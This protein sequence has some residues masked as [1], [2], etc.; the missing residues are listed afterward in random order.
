MVL[1]KMKNKWFFEAV[2]LHKEDPYK[3]NYAE[4][5]RMFDKPYDC[6]RSRF[7]RAKEKEQKQELRIEDAFFKGLKEGKNIYSLY[8]EFGKELTDKTLSDLRDQ[9]VQIK[10]TPTGLLKVVDFVSVDRIEHTE[11]WKAN[12][13]IYFGLVSDTHLCSKWQQLTNLNKIYDIFLQKKEELGLD[14]LI[15]YH[16][17]DLVEGSGMRKGHE[18]EIIAHGFDAQ[19]DYV[20]K[21]YPLREGITTKFI[22]GNHD[23]VFIRSSGSNIG[24]AI[25]KER[26]DMIYLGSNNARI[27]LTPNCT[28]EINHPWDGS[29]FDNQ[30]EILTDRGWVLFKDLTMNDQCA[31]MRKND[32]TFEWQKPDDIY[33]NDY[34]GEMIHFKSRTV[35]MLVTPNHGM[36]VKEYNKNKVGNKLNFPQKAHYSKD[37]NWRM[38]TA[39]TLLDS[40][41][42]QKWQLTNVCSNWEGKIKSEYIEIPYVESKNVGMMKRMKHIGKIH[43]EDLCKL[44]AW[45]VTEG[46]ADNKKVC[47]CQSKRV[48]PENH[49]DITDLLDKLELKYRISGLDDKDIIISSVELSS[50]LQENCG[51]GSKNV[52]LPS[53]LKELPST[54]LKIIFNT[55]IAG[56]GWLTTTGYGYKSIS[57]RLR[58][59]FSEIAIKLGYSVNI[60]QETV[61]VSSIQTMPTINKKPIVVPYSGKVYCCKVPNELILVKRNNRVTW[62]H[63]SY[64]ISYA[65]QKQ[66]ET[67]PQNKKPNIF[68]NG[69]HHKMINLVYQGIFCIE[70]GSFQGHTPFMLGKKLSSTIGGYFLKVELDDLGNCVQ[71]TPEY[72]CFEEMLNDY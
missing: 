55:M 13:T 67:I 70:A 9:G 3:Y 37:Y 7:R 43:I 61:T 12:K 36:W 57:N 41:Y 53:Y 66:V 10:E 52:F 30:T 65:I 48:N 34:N 50:F 32:H 38:E 42:C 27:N 18:Y 56:D 51:K 5:A 19:K 54:Y 72:I 29:C 4:L 46:Y 69:H 16:A 21:N 28:M 15:I 11:K 25:S 14:D 2:N 47:I 24:L 44:M 8:V 60:A 33:I 40:H 35:D 1:I 64:A 62:S 45:Y 59:D 20:I 68:V 22:T 39:K 63:N 6:V 26:E 31:T 23:G 58:D 17:G 71:V 49:K